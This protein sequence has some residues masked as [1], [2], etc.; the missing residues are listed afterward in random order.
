MAWHSLESLCNSDLNHLEVPGTRG[1]TSSPGSGNATSM[2]DSSPDRQQDQSTT[3]VA[4][5]DTSSIF[6]FACPNATLS[7]TEIERYLESRFD[8]PELVGREF[9]D[10]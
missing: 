5:L 3:A 6:H 10:A 4:H 8:L 1:R 2:V 9:A 7:L